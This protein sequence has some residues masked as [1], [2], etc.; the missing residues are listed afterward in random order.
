MN[1]ST[2]EQPLSDVLNIHLLRVVTDENFEDI[3]DEFSDEQRFIVASIRAVAKRTDV[4]SICAFVYS[5]AAASET[6]NFGFQRIAHMQDGYGNIGGNIIVTNQTANNGMYRPCQS[7]TPDNVMDEL[8]TLSFGE[9]CTVIWDPIQRV[10][11][12]YPLGVL[13]FDKY[14]RN[15]ISYKDTDLNQGDI[16]EA[17]D[18]TYSSNLKNPSGHTIKMWSGNKLVERAEEELER[19]LK[20]QLTMYFAGH[21]RRII[22]HVQTNT[23]AGRADLIFLQKLSTGGPNMAGV[24]ELKVLRGPEGKDK[25]VTK[26]GLS[27]GF[28]YRNDLGLPFAILALYDVAE[29]P[30]DNV[31]V[32]LDSQCQRHLEQVE[33]RRYPI[34]DSPKAWRDA[35]GPGSP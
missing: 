17:L 11:T 1:D 10:A 12:I 2:P 28:Y 24:L 19:H 27:Q 35:G 32:L 25:K 6:R 3:P 4:H 30:S 5:E 26:E 31:N 7:N 34:Y 16:L 13:N 8:E 20:G 33:V 21:Q 15:T 18:L 22:I 9:R 29:S 14:V 23:T